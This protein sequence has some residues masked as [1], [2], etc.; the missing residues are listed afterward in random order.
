MKILVV[1]TPHYDFCAASLIE[2]L[3]DLEIAGEVE[4][5]YCTEASNYGA[6]GLKGSQAVL[7]LYEAKQF[8]KDQAG[9][10]IITS[11]NDVKENILEDIAD[12]SKF[13][14]IDGEDVF[15]YKKNPH[16]FALYF[17]RELR[18]EGMVVHPNVKPFPFAA[19]K[20]YFLRKSWYDKKY[21]V[22]CMFGP[23]D[24]TKPWRTDIEKALSA[25]NLKDSLIGAVYGG[26]PLSKIDTGN[27][28]HS[29][30]YEALALSKMSVDAHG[31]YECNSGR[32]WESLANCC[33]LFTRKNL[34]DMPFPFVD[35]EHLIEFETPEELAE[36]LEFY[37]DNTG[38][39][40]HETYIKKIAK[41]GYQHLKTYH[42]TKARA[43]YL[44]SECKKAGII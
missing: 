37:I 10:V 41:A 29:N 32:Y 26:S 20:R 24:T 11:N 34:I 30:Y 33:C 42:T 36:S 17:K 1:Q 3:N 21:S 12:K 16:D 7:E 14:Y 23:H 44:L 27:R 39:I 15:Q 2:G 31:A 6:N 40:Q 18:K 19:E 9:L 25:A 5:L 22:S 35:G 8:A 13:V 28:D 4:E 38:C 43:Q